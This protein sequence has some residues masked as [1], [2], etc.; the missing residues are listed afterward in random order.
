M[1]PNSGDASPTA[2]TTAPRNDRLDVGSAMGKKVK[3]VVGLE[4]RVYMRWQLSILLESLRGKLP[5]G[6]EPWVVVCND[7]RP[8]SVDLQRLLK[9]YGVRHFTGANHPRRETMDFAAGDDV[10][11]PINRIEALNVVADHVGDDDLVCL[12][13]TDIFLYGELNRRVFPTGNALFDNW[14]VRQEIFFTHGGAG[15]QA[16][17]RLPLL[18]E[19]MGVGTPF[20]PGG[21]TIFLDADTVRRKKIIQD[22]FRFA[23]VLYLL[24]TIVAVPKI[25]IAEMPA[26]ALALTANG[27]DFELLT[28]P[29]FTTQN[30]DHATIPSGTFY[31]YYHDLRD[32]GDGAFRGSQWY[33]HEFTFE[34]FLAR[35]LSPYAE[36]ATTDHEREFFEVARRAQRR[37]WRFDPPP[38]IETRTVELRARVRDYGLGFRK[39]TLDPTLFA[40][41]QRRLASGPIANEI[42]DAPDY[43]KNVE[44][45]APTTSFQHDDA[46]N[47][48]LLV[49]LK[50]LHEEWCGFS[51]V[52]SVCY[53]IR[54]YLR[55]TF[56]YEHT[57]RPDTHIIS[58]TICVN[59]ETGEPW[60]LCVED[61]SGRR[62][63]IILEPGEMLF[64][65]GALLRH[66]RPYPL[67]GDFYAGIYLHYRPALDEPT[68]STASATGPC[69]SPEDQT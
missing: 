28:A 5:E 57:D 67:A 62:H 58:S 13:E 41:L 3:F 55:G 46:F 33:K 7:H 23:Q 9:V 36:R 43:V 14:I 12:T 51:L 69:P 10:Y 52:E 19:A 49:A 42:D 48:A 27:V 66:G 35:D 8:L 39:A 20:K 24:G 17:V 44:P 37:V 56:L 32:G 61:S 30:H 4:D 60:P 45:G 1:R 65:E 16:G 40:L 26:V 31:H 59:R 34:N 2:A 47:R 63:H 21:V 11:V 25:W 18:L 15:E 29:E 6:W 22:A 68:G 38:A 53:G 64:Y 54:I 50:P